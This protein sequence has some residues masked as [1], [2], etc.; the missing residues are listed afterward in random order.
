MKRMPTTAERPW[1]LVAFPLLTALMLQAWLLPVTSLP[2]SH[3]D[4]GQMV[5]NLWH[6][7]ESIGKSLSFDLVG[8]RPFSVQMAA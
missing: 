8:L 6:A 1:L 4:S 5:W 3:G 2:S 7:T